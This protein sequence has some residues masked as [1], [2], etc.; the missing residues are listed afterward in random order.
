MRNKFSIA[1][2]AACLT[3]IAGTA[4]ASPADVGIGIYLGAPAPVHVAPPPPVVHYG[5][6][7]YATPRAAYAAPWHGVPAPRRYAQRGHAMYQGGYEGRH[8]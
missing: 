4:A 1:V 6:P 2:L 5:P 7:V 3:G 8:R